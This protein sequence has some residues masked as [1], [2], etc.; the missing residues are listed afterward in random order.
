M[1][2]GEWCD[3]CNARTAIEEAEALLREAYRLMTGGSKPI[4]EEVKWAHDTDRYFTKRHPND[5]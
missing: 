5:E 3:V 2:E 1:P 4:T